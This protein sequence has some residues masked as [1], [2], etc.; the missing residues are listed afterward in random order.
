MS[1]RKWNKSKPPY[2]GWWSIKTHEFDIPG[3]FWSFFV[4]ECGIA[5]VTSMMHI[6]K[7]GHL[8]ELDFFNLILNGA[9]TGLKMP[10]YQE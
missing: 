6:Q 8:R 1:N 10:A 3:E 9:T 7:Y 2:D 4:M 5:L